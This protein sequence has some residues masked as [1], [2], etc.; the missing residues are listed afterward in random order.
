VNAHQ[1]RKAQRERTR[2]ETREFRAGPTSWDT[3]S[4]EDDDADLPDGL[5]RDAK[6]TLMYECRACGKSDEWPAEIADFDINN[7]ANMCSGSPLCC[8]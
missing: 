8:P 4:D 3:D 2:R 6:G 7:Y 1:R 5:W